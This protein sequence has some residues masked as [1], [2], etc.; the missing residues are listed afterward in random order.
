MSMRTRPAAHILHPT[1]FTTES[2]VALAHAL[3]LALTNHAEIH[4][5]H[6]GKDTREEWHEFPSIREYLRRWGVI[7]EGASRSDVTDL[8]IGIE[9]VIGVS[10]SV[11]DAI[12]GYCQRNPIDMIGKPSFTIFSRT[13]PSPCSTSSDHAIG[14]FLSASSQNIAFTPRG[15]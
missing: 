4:L 1:D 8:G 15:R 11:S 2:D 14:S 10:S 3:K 13:L 12:E 7:G 6:I 9:K 5:L